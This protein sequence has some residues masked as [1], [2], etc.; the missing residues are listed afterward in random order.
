GLPSVV[1][2]P[3][4]GRGPVCRALCGCPNRP[5]G[6]GDF[7]HSPTSPQVWAAGPRLWHSPGGGLMRRIAELVLRHRKLVVVA[8]LLVVVAGMALTQKTNNRLVV[9]FSLPGQ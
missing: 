3:Q 8:W 1:S 4:H 2:V 5:P 9:D 7:H 6:S